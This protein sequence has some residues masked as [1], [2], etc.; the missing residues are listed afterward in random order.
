M[1]QGTGVPHVDLPAFQGPLDLLL[2]L[3][4]Q[5][6][7]D[8]YDIPIARVADQFVAA[9]EQMEALD[10]EVASGFLVLAAQLLYLKSKELLPKPKFTEESLEDETDYKK[11][12]VDRLIAYRAIKEAAEQL[13]RSEGATGSRYFRAIDPEEIVAGL[14]LKDPLD[15]VAFGDVLSAFRQ[16]LERADKGD[17]ETDVRFIS[18][19]AISIDVVIRDVLRR[20]LLQPKGVYFGLLLRYQSRVEIVMAFLALLELLKEG[21]IKA[22][23]DSEP[24]RDDIFL[25]PT[26][27]A[28]DFQMDLG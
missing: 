16:V 10:I 5:H 1:S 27:K 26:E 8:I 14:P 20:I 19:E 22:Q 28:W 9:I 24:G 25:V 13:R 17:E 12:L 2:H 6:K 11:D 21:K 15:S 3:I 23:Q 4:G 18:L 7:I